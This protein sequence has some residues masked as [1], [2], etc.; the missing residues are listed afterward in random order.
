M[1]H[2]LHQVARHARE[3]EQLRHRHFRQRADDL[4]HVAAGAEVSAGA[5]NDDRLGL[6]FV[7]QAA[8]EVAQLG[9]RLEGQRILLLG[10]IER[11]DAHAAFPAPLEMLRLAHDRTS[12][13]WLFSLASSL[14]R[15]S[16]SRRDRP[17]S[18]ATTNYSCARAISVNV[19]SPAR[20]RPLEQ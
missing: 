12:T 2:R 10:A 5:G 20:V 18:S 15:S 17:E 1:A 6:L 11:N 7:F 4:V 14:S 3:L 13:A 19:P 9:V 8:E 16:C